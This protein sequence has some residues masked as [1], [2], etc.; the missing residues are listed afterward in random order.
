MNVVSGSNILGSSNMGDSETEVADHPLRDDVTDPARGEEEGE[1]R[2]E[3]KNGHYNENENNSSNKQDESHHDVSMFDA[4]TE[5]LFN[6]F[7]DGYCKVSRCL[8]ALLLLLCLLAGSLLR[9]PCFLTTITFSFAKKSTHNRHLS[10]PMEIIRFPRVPHQ[11]STQLPNTRHGIT[12]LPHPADNTQRREATVTHLVTFASPNLAL[13][14]ELVAE[15]KINA[16]RGLWP[17]PSGMGITGKTTK[18][19]G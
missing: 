9:F 18:A 8:T 2:D 13:P 12:I 19:E 5:L 7:L 4:L 16:T 6:P 14:R 3:E 10:V 15:R 1:S 17:W 11:A